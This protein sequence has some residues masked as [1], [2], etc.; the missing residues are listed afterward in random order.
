[1]RTAREGTDSGSS[2]A[3]HHPEGHNS[4]TLLTKIIGWLEDA[5]AEDIISIDLDGKSSIG[6]YM[7]VATGRSDRHVGAIAD[8]IRRKLKEHGYGGIKVEGKD[9]C[10]W[11]LIDNGDIIIHVFRPEVREFYNLEKMWAAD[12]PVDETAH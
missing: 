3:E 5:K 10:D 4:A 1:M 9:S 2:M 12:R 6:D 7:L 11:V 8:Q